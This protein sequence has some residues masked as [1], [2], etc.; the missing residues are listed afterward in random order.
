MERF[1]LVALSEVH[2]LQEFYDFLI[3]IWYHTLLPEKITEI[4]VEF[5]KTHSQEIANRFLL[6]DQPV[7][8]ADL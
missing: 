6:T 8:K 5:G 4:V 2:Q 7:A 1:P 3:V